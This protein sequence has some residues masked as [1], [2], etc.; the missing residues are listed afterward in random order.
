MAGLS[1][2]RL[3][4]GGWAWKVPETK[5]R[6]AS[7]FK[8]CDNVGGGAVALPRL[9]LVIACIELALPCLASRSAW[10]EVLPGLLSTTN[11]RTSP[12]CIKLLYYTVAF[13]LP[14]SPSSLP[15]SFIP[16]CTTSTTYV[17]SLASLFYC[18][19]CVGMT[20]P[21]VVEAPS[22]HVSFPYGSLHVR[23]VSSRLVSSSRLVTSRVWFIAASRAHNLIP[24]PLLHAILCIASSLCPWFYP[25][26]WGTTQ[27]VPR[28]R[29]I[30]NVAA[31]SVNA[32]NWPSLAFLS[33]DPPEELR[34]AAA[35]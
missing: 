4:S 24:G 7:W 3:V 8:A 27:S 26:R 29:K 10:E 30:N 28:G 31:S 35:S 17:S 19:A 20:P 32:L 23:L 6:S 22:C 11:G 5:G 1:L 34:P 15:P 12:A 2:G 33:P 13:S 21:L 9:G 25:R 16:S 18:S 14:P